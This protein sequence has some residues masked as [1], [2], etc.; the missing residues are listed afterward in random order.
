MSSLDIGSKF[1]PSTPS[2]YLGAIYMSSDA[3]SPPLFSPTVAR[4]NRRRREGLSGPFPSLQGGW[5][6]AQRQ[7]TG[8]PQMQTMFLSML[9]DS[10]KTYDLSAASD[11]L[12]PR[13]GSEREKRACNLSPR[14]SLCLSRQR[15]AIENVQSPP[16]CRLELI[17]LRF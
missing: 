17:Y 4:E 10:D 7:G 14:P 11:A 15:R 9:L 2:S 3:S 6:P 5:K 13:A 12:H 16:Y 8:R 1:F